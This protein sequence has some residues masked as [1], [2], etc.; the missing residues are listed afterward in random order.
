MT[1]AQKEKYLTIAK[2]YAYTAVVA[3]GAAIAMGKTEPRQLFIAA[4]VGAF[5][6]AIVA[7]NPAALSYGINAAPPAIAELAKEVVAESKKATKPAA[8]KAP[9]KKT[10]TPKK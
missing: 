10:S 7:L 8:K 5:G 9:A 6:P 2:H 3:I 1:D 4:L